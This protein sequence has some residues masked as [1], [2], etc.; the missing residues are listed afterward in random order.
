MAVSESTWKKVFKVV[1]DA[2]A[3]MKPNVLQ[4]EIKCP[5]CGKHTAYIKRANPYN[6]GDH[7]SAACSR[8]CFSIKE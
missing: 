5:I 1:V 3:R 6:Q 4:E 2:R 8:G 7:Y